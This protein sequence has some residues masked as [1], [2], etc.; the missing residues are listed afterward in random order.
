MCEMNRWTWK[1][2]GRGY[3]V[4]RCTR[5]SS[6]PETETEKP[7]ERRNSTAVPAATLALRPADD[8]STK[9]PA[10]PYRRRPDDILELAAQGDRRAET[11]SLRDALHRKLGLLE[12]P[13][14]EA[15]ALPLEPLERRR[16]ELRVEAPR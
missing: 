16:P 7:A 15:H 12:Q 14:G 1:T 3:G 5:C 6:R 13:L 10:I 8:P 9:G 2:S 11:R 4:R